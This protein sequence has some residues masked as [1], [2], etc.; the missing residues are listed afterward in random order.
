MITLEKAKKEDCQR[1][2]RWRNDPRVREFFFDSHEISYSEHHKWF[3]ES[4]GRDD[5]IILIA[6]DGHRALG[7]LR[8]DMVKTEPWAA[9][10][11]V[12]VAPELQGLG[13]GKKMLSGGERWVKKNT[14]ITKL[15]AKVKETNQASLRMFAHCG[16]Q[17]E[18]IFFKKEIN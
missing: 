16:F 13:F 17:T 2:F 7:V 11:D 3:E 10:I 1:I 14:E 4:L 9:E 6:Y 12:Y 15:F 5:R 18:F 8:F